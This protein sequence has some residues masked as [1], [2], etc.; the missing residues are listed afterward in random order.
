MQHLKQPIARRAN[1]ED[2][3][4][5]HFFEQRFYSGALLSEEAVLAAMAYVD[6][7]PVRAKLARRLAQCQHASI[8]AR[9]LE[10]SPAA[11]AD[12]L[13][14]L[15]SGLA[16]GGGQKAAAAGR[17]R[18]RRTGCAIARRPREHRAANPAR[19]LRHSVRPKTRVSQSFSREHPAANRARSPAARVNI[20]H[21][22]RPKT[23][24]SQS[25]TRDHRDP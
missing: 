12:F 22:V 6:L 21:S 16:R 25:F 17:P 9:L 20:R 4:K 2:G 11:L 13:R 18:R 15:E 14:L 8:S 7:N 1:E 10:N 19:N 23:R 3:C 24:V 5:G